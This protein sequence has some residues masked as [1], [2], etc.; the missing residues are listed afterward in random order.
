MLLTKIVSKRLKDSCFINRN[1]NGVQ[2]LDLLNNRIILSLQL[3]EAMISKL[4]VSI[5]WSDSKLKLN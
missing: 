3:N 4:M 5:R 1:F 2:C